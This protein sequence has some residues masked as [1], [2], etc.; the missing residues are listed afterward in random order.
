M[1]CETEQPTFIGLGVSLAEKIE[2]SIKTMQCHEAIALSI[3]PENGYYGC[4]SGG[5]D[6]IVVKEIARRA[7]VKIKWHYSVTTIDP[8]ELVRFIRAVHPDVEWM[9]PKQNFFT[10]MAVK[11]LPTRRMRW[12]CEEFKET[13]GAGLL[14]VTGIRAAESPRRAK[15]WSI[16]TP[17]KGGKGGWVQNPILHWSDENVW[18]FIRG[19]KLPYCSLYDEGFKRLGCVGCPMSSNRRKELERWA[20]YGR[21]WKQAALKFWDLM[22]SEKRDTRTA[23]SFSSGEE[24]FEWWLS[25]EPMP[26]EDADDCQMG[27]F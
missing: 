23:R 10:R 20:G 13:G 5:K 27:L 2:I 7:G 1:T 12:C 11:G 24:W 8:P 22:I 25:N 14:K 9:R 16:M 15:A 18:E 4:F 3:D 6:S 17:W 19:E 26:S 21:N